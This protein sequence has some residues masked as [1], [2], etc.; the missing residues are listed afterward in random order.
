MLKATVSSKGQVTLPKPA[1][2][3]LGI[4][5]GTEL[6]VV[7]DQQTIQLRKIEPRWRRWYGALQGS[8]ALRELEKEHREEIE[9]DEA[10]AGRRKSP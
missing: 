10:G 1:R 5:A 4:A 7:V 3:Q 8:E 2:E 9:R 6:E